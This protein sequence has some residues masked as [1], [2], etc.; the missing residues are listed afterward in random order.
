MIIW[1]IGLS[2]SG[3]TTLGQ[4]MV[5]QWKKTAPNTVLVDGDEMR[6]LFGLNRSAADYSIEGR[7]QN[8][9]RIVDLCCWLDR[10]GINAVCCI[11]SIFHD[12]QKENRDRFSDYFEIFMDVPLQIARQRDR[13]ELYPVGCKE[14]ALN[15]VGLD[16]SFE[17]PPLADL[18]IDNSDE[19]GDIGAMARFALHAAGISVE[20]GK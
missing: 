17:P 7:R 1:V 11:L 16:I 5:E 20:E 12:M 19:E 2:A 15:I 4:E 6:A 14:S 3:K 18:F 13:K 10:Q 9:Q 8:G